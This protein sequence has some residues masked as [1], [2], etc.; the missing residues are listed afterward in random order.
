MITNHSQPASSGGWYHKTTGEER[1]DAAGAVFG[2]GRSQ[3]DGIHVARPVWRGWT[4]GN[5]KSGF[6][7]IP[8]ILQGIGYIHKPYFSRTLLPK[9]K[10]TGQRVA[11]RFEKR[12]LRGYLHT[13]FPEG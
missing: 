12:A 11:N 7:C 2:S 6:C 13:K 8:Y 9:Q 1:S 10:E 4:H 3:Q 5:Y